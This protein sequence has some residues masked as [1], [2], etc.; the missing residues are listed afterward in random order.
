MELIIHPTA[1]LAFQS[2][3]SPQ[4][5]KSN[6]VFFEKLD[7]FR[8]AIFGVGFAI[9]LSLI[10][11]LRDPINPDLNLARGKVMVLLSF[12]SCLLVIY[13]TPDPIALC[14]CCFKG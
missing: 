2:V 1:I 13:Y 6:G 14:L 10:F 5:R 8:F 9:A 7:L 12:W 4:V 3:A 11:I